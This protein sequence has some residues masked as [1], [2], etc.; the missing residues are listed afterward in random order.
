MI[1]TYIRVEMSSDG[2]S[3]KQVIE[4]MRR[5]G[6]VP[7]VGD[8]DFELNLGEE[9][10]LFDR[11][12]EIHRTLRGSGARYSVTTRTEVVESESGSSRHQITHLVGQRPLELR[13]KF[14][15]AKLERW[16]EMGLDVSELEPILERDLDHFKEASK[17]FL[18]THLDKVAVVKD[19]AA[20]QTQLDAV[21]LSH[22]DEVCKTLEELSAV[23]GRSE[24]ELVLS[25]GRLISSGSVKLVQ[26]DGKEGYCLAS[27]P[28]PQDEKAQEPPQPITD[29]EAEERVLAAL[30]ESGASAKALARSTGLPK[31][32]TAK[33][34]SA[35][36]EKGKVKRVKRDKRYMYT[37]V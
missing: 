12:E 20:P 8:Y 29:E 18:R 32:K 31:D 11:L 6:A 14:Y 25:L 17:E 1:K 16:K 34:L 28:S 10:R 7:V 3:P 23:I 26:K 2:E 9:E 33:A 21:V 5:I 37:R 15:R 35:L 13:R 22:M 4:R 19:T 24:D 36:T 30:P 27:H